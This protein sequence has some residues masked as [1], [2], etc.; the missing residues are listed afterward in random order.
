MRFVVFRL[1]KYNYRS[2]FINL[3]NT[4]LRIA[5]NL[6][7]SKISHDYLNQNIE[8][9]IFLGG[10]GGKVL[11]REGMEVGVDGIGERGHGEWK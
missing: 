10:R 9:I 3:F 1:L 2:S 7:T 5:F 6:L 11:S 8:C 4:D